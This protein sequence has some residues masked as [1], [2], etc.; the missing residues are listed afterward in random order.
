MVNHESQRM[1][2]R[3]ECLN[4]EL[5]L[6]IKGDPGRGNIMYQGTECSGSMGTSSDSEWMAFGKQGDA[7]QDIGPNTQAGTT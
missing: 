7:W 5:S 2:Q 4:W 6:R 3:R 1:F